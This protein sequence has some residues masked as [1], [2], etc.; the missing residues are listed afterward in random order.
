[1]S[2]LVLH[3]GQMK[4]GTTYLQRILAKNRVTL[5]QAGWNYP[6]KRENHQ[7]AI[8]GLCRNDIFW[9]GEAKSE[10]SKLAEALVT[11]TDQSRE[12]ILISAEA[13][14]VLY[15]NSISRLTAKI[16]RP[17]RVLLTV[18]NLHVTLPSA[19]QQSVKSRYTHSLG[20]FFEQLA[21][22]R[23]SLQ[24]HWRTYAFGEVVRR[25]S[26]HAPVTVVVVPPAD[27]GGASALWGLF[28]E[29]VGLSVT[30]DTN[31]NPDEANISVNME[32]TEML[33][34]MNA[35]MAGADLR[36]EQ[37]VRLKNSYLRE[38]V[39]PCAKVRRGSAVLPP[40]EYSTALDSWNCE[41]LEKLKHNASAIVGDITHLASYRG[42]FAPD[43]N[44]QAS[45]VAAEFA[46]QYIS[47]W[48]LKNAGVTA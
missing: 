7:H 38:F 21:R 28:S 42:E 44:R 39:A 41:E 33:R 10:W 37:M 32:T 11:I 22:D 9:V 20:D 30:V 17:D 36:E 15:T 47:H 2:E 31:V 3:V 43:S 48:R 13:L 29:A 1:M 27:S 18:R 35:A 45:A 8:Y 23:P 34:A 19:W 12:R 26:H 4:S 24:G 46:L 16:G 25:W 6:G 40:A 14:S 5:R